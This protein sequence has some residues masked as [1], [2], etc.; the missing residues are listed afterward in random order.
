MLGMMTSSTSTNFKRE[1]D[2]AWVAG[3]MS[4]MGEFKIPHRGK[5]RVQLLLGS[6]KHPEPI[7]MVAAYFKTP[8]VLM[9]GR[10]TLRLSGE[11][12]DKA[13]DRVWPYLSEARK[14]EYNG[15][16]AI[17]Q[18]QMNAYAADKKQKQLDQ[19]FWEGRSTPS[20]EERRARAEA[21]YHNQDPAVEVIEDELEPT[22]AEVELAKVRRQLEEQRQR[23][24][25]P[26]IDYTPT[27]KRG[28]KNA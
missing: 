22:E 19:K 10:L 15:L 12:L 17:Q 24:E 1:T 26:W 13:L 5:P 25:M 21:S 2:A 9:S 4:V 6:T 20:D 27:T 16:V 18:Q 8:L 11:Q 23:A 28:K 3:I 14:A 7:E